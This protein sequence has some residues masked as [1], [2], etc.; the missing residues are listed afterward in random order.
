[1]FIKSLATFLCFW[2][3]IIAKYISQCMLLLKHVLTFQIFIY[4]RKAKSNNTHL[5]LKFSNK[6]YHRTKL[7][8]MP[9][10]WLFRVEKNG[11]TET[12]S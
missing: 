6:L 2:H 1:M 3:I 12:I 11:G 8:Y 5:L 7:V 10:H 9:I 4:Y